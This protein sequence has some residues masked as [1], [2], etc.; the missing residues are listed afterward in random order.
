MDT[1]GLRRAQDDIEEEGVRRTRERLSQA[2]LVIWVVDGSEPLKKEDGDLLALVESRK[3]VVA[4]NKND[5]PPGF[6]PE[7]LREKI[8]E[9]PWVSVSAL[10]G[11][12][13]ETLK[14][15]IRRMVLSGKTEAPGEAIVSNLR[16]KQAIERA[17]RAL[18]QAR[19]S[20]SAGLSAEFISLD[21]R[22]AQASL[23]EIAG[24]HTAED[25]L[26]RIFSQFCVGK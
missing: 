4:V 18:N 8:P 2:D 7:S 16:H 1:A 5:L 17:I 19:E 15:E 13:I 6:P 10:R 11:L 12:G 22:E 23:G 9:A 3:T 26:E 24:T 20:L 25:I 14:E 21:L